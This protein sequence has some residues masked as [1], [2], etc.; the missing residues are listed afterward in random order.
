MFENVAGRTDDRRRTTDAGVTGILIAHLGAFGSGELK[1]SDFGAQK[2]S[3]ITITNSLDRAQ[4][5]HNAGPELDT[6][7]L[8]L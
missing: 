4:A 3:L 8:M 5:R 6:N 7:C 1:T 2:N